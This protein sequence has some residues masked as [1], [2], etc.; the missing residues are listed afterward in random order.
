MA[1]V[2]IFALKGLMVGGARVSARLK[3]AVGGAIGTIFV[4]LRSCPLKHWPRLGLK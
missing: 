4:T 3:G 1:E 2:L